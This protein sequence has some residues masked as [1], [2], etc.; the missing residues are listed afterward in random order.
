MARACVRELTDSV[1]VRARERVC[2]QRQI[3]RPI[4]R[5]EVKDDIH[6]KGQRQQKVRYNRTSPSIRNA[7]PYTDVPP[8]ECFVHLSQNEESSPVH[9]NRECFVTAYR[10]FT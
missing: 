5:S 4:G 8:V 6:S 3:T 9:L 1:L 7:V 2:V 10:F